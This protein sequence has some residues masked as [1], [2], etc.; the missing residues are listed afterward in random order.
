MT[1]PR[2]GMG[3]GA[4]E[5]AERQEPRAVLAEHKMCGHWGEELDSPPHV[6]HRAAI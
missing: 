5:D 2:K 4:H 6:K 3:W 1:R